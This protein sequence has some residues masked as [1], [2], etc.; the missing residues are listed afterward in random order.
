MLAHVLI[1]LIY[2]HGFLEKSSGIIQMEFDSAEKCLKAAEK[3]Q[4]VYKSDV[5]RTDCVVIEK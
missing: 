1:V 5:S 2:S 4:K 3:V